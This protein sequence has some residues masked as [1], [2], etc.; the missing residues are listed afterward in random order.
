MALAE[1]TGQRRP[2]SRRPSGRGPAAQPT[3][4]RQNWGLLN[5]AALASPGATLRMHRCVLHLSSST[6][7]PER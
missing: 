3:C 4:A 5:C 1:S 2:C 7:S 6:T